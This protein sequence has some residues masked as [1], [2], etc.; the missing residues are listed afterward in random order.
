MMAL[1]TNKTVDKAI[2]TEL[3][4]N[5]LGIEIK[6]EQL[7]SEN[8]KREKGFGSKICSYFSR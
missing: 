7:N 2:N 4:N 8:E 1:C 6:S 5:Y 3:G